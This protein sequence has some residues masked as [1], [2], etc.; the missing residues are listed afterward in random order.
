LI[1]T[2]DELGVELF[3]DGVVIYAGEN[4]RAILYTAEAF[5]IFKLLMRVFIRSG[6]LSPA[7]L[8]YIYHEQAALAPEEQE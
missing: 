3:S 1:P 4:E 5:E 8:D 7:T 2:R 6:V